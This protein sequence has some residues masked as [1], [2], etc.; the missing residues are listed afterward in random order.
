ML[1]AGNSK[2]LL[3]PGPL[4]RGSV[5]E[6]LNALLL[7]TDCAISSVMSVAK[8]GRDTRGG[9]HHRKLQ[10]K[11]GEVQLR[12]PRLWPR[13]FETAIKKSRFAGLRILLRRYGARGASP[14]TVLDLNK[15]IYGSCI[16]GCS[17]PAQTAK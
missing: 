5:K 9:H 7:E 3:S 15:K 16:K 12:I 6:M 14:S 8:T 17:G 11:A 1:E 13:I 2:N 4:V 10:T